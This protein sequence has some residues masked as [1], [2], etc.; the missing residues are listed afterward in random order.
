MLDFSV[1]TDKK[2]QQT[3]IHTSIYGKHL[4]ALPQLNKGTAFTQSERE[5]FGLLGKLPLHRQHHPTH[6]R[7][8]LR[9]PGLQ[10]LQCHAVSAD[11]LPVPEFNLTEK[12]IIPGFSWRSE[13]AYFLC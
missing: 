7:P 9:P 12:R 13:K 3:S 2:T 11:C 5:A 1:V 4:L 6:L 10:S 8:Q